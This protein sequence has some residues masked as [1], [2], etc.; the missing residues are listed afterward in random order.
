[1]ARLVLC[2]RSKKLDHLGTQRCNYPFQDADSGILQAAFQPADVA[3]VNARI[4]G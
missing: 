4:D 3:Q 1:M 2:G